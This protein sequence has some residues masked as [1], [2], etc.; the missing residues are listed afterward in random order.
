MTPDSPSRLRSVLFY[1]LRVVF[2]TLPISEA[3]GDRLREQ[4]LNRF[5]TIRPARR[6][7]LPASAR[8]RR[9]NVHSGGRA[10]GYVEHRVE[11]L[12]APLPATLVAFYL[13]QFHTIPENDEWWGKGFTEWRNVARALP[14]F[15]GHA[16]P[17]LPGDLGFYDLRN[18]H[19]MH[20]QAKLAREYGISAFCFYLYWFAGKTLLEDPLQQWL[21]DPSIDL[22]FCL[23]W[24][25]ENWSRRWDGHAEEVLIAQ[26]HGADD[27]LEFIA[28]ISRYLRD[29]RYLRVDNKPLLLVYRPS[30]LPDAKAT[31]ARWRT[32]CSAHGIGEIFIAYVQGFE[33]EDPRDLGFDA[34]VEFPPNLATPTDITAQ[35]R[36]LNPTYEGQILD[37][38]VLAG[39]YQRRSLPAYRLFPGVNCGWDN[40]PRRGNRGRTYLH[41][42]PYAYRTWL[43]DTI[44]RRLEGVPCSER[45]IF[46]NAWNEW[47]EGAVLEPDLRLGHAWLQ[48][49]RSALVRSAST[50]SRALA[51]CAVVHAWYPEVLRGVLT[52]L[53][54]SGL[55]CKLI[56]TTSPEKEAEVRAVLQSEGS[57]AELH[58]AE[59]RGR[60]ILPFLRLA[61]R[62][63]EDGQDLVLK[64]HTKRSPHLLEGDRWREEILQS[65]LSPQNVPR[66]LEAFRREANLGLVAPDGHLLPI[67][68]HLGANADTVDYLAR[69]MGIPASEEA[70]FHF[71]SGSMFWVRLDAL[72]PILDA[73]LD[74]W[75]FEAE[76]GQIDGTLA[77]ALE[78][79]F[80][81]SAAACNLKVATVASVCGGS[82]WA[83]RHYPYAHAD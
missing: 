64:L 46:V 19:V 37:W 67:T 60:D 54:T 15:E 44:A 22:S 66:I 38:R 53:R 83:R 2:R 65:L 16:Q 62:L 36:F 14:Q 25:N 73:H 26:S 76:K 23:C 69:R 82:E 47:A 70:S 34:A 10:L 11:P 18:P 1:A 75:E 35:Q 27:D 9:P 61:Y 39:D 52:K 21:N 43:Q 56:V 7:G 4:F 31:A 6:H 80:A 48:A 77:H 29:P 81:L 24:A 59:N 51:P 17:R 57:D 58:V 74:E 79:T 32:W 49:T 42:A 13:P 33:R 50:G 45:L 12:P 55:E 72:A 41:A 3:A 8:V 63:R 28:H 71:I 30:L 40:E 20:D 78:R 68:G 5:P